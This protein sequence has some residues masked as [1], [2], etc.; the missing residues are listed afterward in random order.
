MQ[1]VTTPVV[2]RWKVYFLLFLII[3]LS[4]IFMKNVFY[5]KASEVYPWSP[6]FSSTLLEDCD[7]TNQGTVGRQLQL[8]AFNFLN[9]TPGAKKKKNALNWNRIQTKFGPLNL[10]GDKVICQFIPSNS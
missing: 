3:F 4:D 6:P 1:Y 9:T 5:D 7:S 10:E 2:C 8:R